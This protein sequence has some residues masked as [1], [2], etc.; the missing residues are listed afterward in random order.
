M[1]EGY[2][3]RHGR[4]GVEIIEEACP[5][6]RHATPRA[7][8]Y[9]FIGTAPF[10]AGLLYFWSSMSRS[11]SA[12]DDLIAS[13]LGLTLLFVWMKGCQARFARV[14]VAEWS[15]HEASPKLRGLL[16]TFFIQGII[17]PSALFV[18]PIAS[19]IMLPLPWV[20]AFY[21]NVTALDDGEKDLGTVFRQAGR[22]ASLWPRQNMVLLLLLS[23]FGF[24]VFLNLLIFCVGLPGLL[25]TF[26]GI[27]TIASQNSYSLLNST[28]FATVMGLTYLCV[29]PLLKAAYALRCFYGNSLQS[30]DDLKTELRFL[31][32]MP[33]AAMAIAMLLLGTGIMQGKD[34]PGPIAP[35]S[36]ETSIEG[37]KLDHNITEV[38]KQE[39]YTWRYAP[40]K[41]EVVAEKGAIPQFFEQ[42]GKAIGK[43][44]KYIINILRKIWHFFDPHKKD[45][46]MP[47]RVQENGSVALRLGLL[48]G[49]LAVIASLLGVVL[50]RFLKARRTT[51]EI[52]A[53]VAVTP[54]PDI[55]DEYIS[56]DQFPE[57]QWTTYG[58]E[59]MAQGDLRSAIRAFYLASLAHLGAVKLVTIA[60]GKSNREYEREVKRRGHALPE[61]PPLFGENVRIFDRAWYGDHEVNQEMVEGF[62]A[63][64]TKIK[65]VS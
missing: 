39:K 63:N 64:L 1:K 43:A 12:S 41:A 52:T 9:Y 23:C 31:N 37:K 5:L 45:A 11:A 42:I 32:R 55:A 30:G 28:M 15:G 6:I 18:L 34:A 29:D 62:V 50:V 27:Q 38:L 21:Q 10:V 60:R 2:L 53:S 22:Q 40:E 36:T 8:A 17:Q 46:D 61:L 25:K 49:A 47:D 51:A 7:L 48:F 20:Y 65:S 35:P 58:R 16:N 14:L 3:L 13:S 4:T 26:L 33:A 44:L 57:D 59:L 19:L 24:F 54:V 56:A